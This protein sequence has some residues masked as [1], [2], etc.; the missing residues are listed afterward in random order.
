MIHW[1]GLF[2]YALVFVTGTASLGVLM[3]T[4]MLWWTRKI[5]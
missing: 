2:T 3:A 5:D 1:L 4:I